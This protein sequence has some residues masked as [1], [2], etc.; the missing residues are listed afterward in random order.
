MKLSETV[1]KLRAFGLS[2]KDIADKVNVSQ[3]TIFRI[4]SGQ[5]LDPKVSIANGLVTLLEQLEAA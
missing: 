2:Q 3:P 1:K 4:E 5:Q